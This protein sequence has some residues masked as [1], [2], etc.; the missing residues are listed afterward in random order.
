MGGGRVTGEEPGGRRVTLTTVPA[1][2]PG[3]SIGGLG[4]TNVA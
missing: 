2:P 4:A 3:A 1:P